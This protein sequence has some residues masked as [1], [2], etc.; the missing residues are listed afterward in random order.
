MPNFGQ[1]GIYSGGAVTKGISPDQ[2]IY[3]SPYI[4]NLYN[5]TNEG[6]GESYEN[7]V[8]KKISIFF[9]GLPEGTVTDQDTKAPSYQINTGGSPGSVW[10]YYDESK[11]DIAFSATSLANVVTFAKVSWTLPL[12]MD[13]VSIDTTYVASPNNPN[14]TESNLIEVEDP[15]KAKHLYFDGQKFIG[16]RLNRALINMSIVMEAMQEESLSSIGG[17]FFLTLMSTADLQS[18][19]NIVTISPVRHISRGPTYKYKVFQNKENLDLG[20]NIALRRT[21]ASASDVNGDNLYVVIHRVTGEL[22]IVKASTEIANYDL[23]TTHYLVARTIAPQV[24]GVLTGVTNLNQLQWEIVNNAA[25]L[26]AVKEKLTSYIRGV[27]HSGFFNTF[28]VQETNIPNTIFVPD[29][30]GNIS[31]ESFFTFGNNL[32]LTAPPVSGSRQDFIFLQ[33]TK[34]YTPDIVTYATVRFASDID[35]STNQDPFASANVKALL[36]D[37]LTLGNVFTYNNE[38]FYQSFGNAGTSEYLAIPIA[39]VHRFNDSP[40]STGNLNGASLGSRPDGKVANMIKS[41]EILRTAIFNNSLELNK[42][43]QESINRI[44]TSTLDSA[45]EKSLGSLDSYSKAPLQVDFLGSYGYGT[46]IADLDGARRYWSGNPSSSIPMGFQFTF[47][48]AFT[49]PYG[50]FSYNIATSESVLTLR[51]P[52][53]SQ[54]NAEIDTDITGQPLNVKVQWASDGTDV[55]LIGIWTPSFNASGDLVNIVTINLNT[56]SINYTAH[57]FGN[58]KINVSFNVKYTSKNT[59]TRPPLTLFKAQVNNLDGKDNHY[60]IASSASIVATETHILNKSSSRLTTVNSIN[61]RDSLYVDRSGPNRKN[62]GYLL[63]YYSAGNGL[64]NTPYLIQDT[65]SINTG[66]FPLFGGTYKIT[67]LVNAFRLDGTPI[68]I[69][70]AIW[71]VANTQFKVFLSEPISTTEPIYFTLGLEGK[72]IDLNYGS[73]EISNLTNAEVIE[74]LTT[75]AAEYLRYSYFDVPNNIGGHPIFGFSSIADKMIMYVE[76][77][78]IGL[79]LVSVPVQVEG[80]S[81]SLISIKTVISTSTYNALTTEQKTCYEINGGPLGGYRLATGRVIRFSLLRAINTTDTIVI[82]YLFGASG[83]KPFDTTK[84]AKFLHS[85][86]ILMTTDGTANEGSTIYSPVSMRLPIVQD[87]SVIGIDTPS[88]TG[89]HPANQFQQT[90]VYINPGTPVTFD[91]SIS[92]S[93]YV[94]KDT[95]VIAFI[96]LIEQDHN[97]YVFVYQVREGQLV[98]TNPDQAFVSHL[99]ER[100]RL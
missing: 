40:Y 73:L 74:G 48:Q 63:K 44:L 87:V 67:G 97:I 69:K 66:D 9:G 8:A 34:K 79:G 30:Y 55:D 7:G 89:I 41:T 85:G 99:V 21:F 51:V 28:D 90:G 68:G 36:D 50:N 47:N 81:K 16:G 26:N 92:F 93:M 39:V 20:S 23:N 61:Y 94:E 71:D 58:A 88:Q 43:L 91:G 45:L 2:N 82:P 1:R 5:N 70:Q 57:A 86:T 65:Y 49:Y 37:D 72:Q 46:K 11:H 12:T 32:T 4:L 100:V 75:P 25:G 19:A 35:Y 84:P 52:A 76:S 6:V 96:S 29:L 3:I 95:G 17:D 54:D 78:T 62:Y 98:F 59:L 77:S 83:F 56:T 24:A 60:C 31:G 42:V 80:F 33:V 53:S 27:S 13:N 38:G 22:S 10:I 14:R 18:N 64:T 15:H